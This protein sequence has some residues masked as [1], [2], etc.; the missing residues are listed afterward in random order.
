MML[1]R[2]YESPKLPSPSGKSSCFETAQSRTLTTLGEKNWATS[3][4]ES[5]VE[6]VLLEESRI[7]LGIVCRERC[8]VD[9]LREIVGS[10]YT[11]RWVASRHA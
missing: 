7:L 5:I 2:D 8:V 6:Y 1:Q 4:V 3:L 9:G 11:I 10:S